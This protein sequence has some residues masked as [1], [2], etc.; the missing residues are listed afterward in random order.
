MIV[1]FS[2]GT[3]MRQTARAL[4]R[5]GI[6]STHIITVFDSGGSSRQLRLAFGMPAVGDLRN[7]L[8]AMA[9]PQRANAAAFLNLR[10]PENADDPSLA[11]AWLDK[12]ALPQ[13]MSA[14]IRR[15]F[16]FFLDNVPASF[17]ASRASLGNMAITGAYLRFGR[18]LVKAID[19]YAKLLGIKG[20]ILPVSNAC[21]QLAAHLVDDQIIIGQ[22][23]FKSLPAAVDSIYLCGEDG[24][25]EDALAEPNALAA[26]RAADII[27]Y[28]TGSFYSSLIANLL[29]VGVGSAIA[30]SGAIKLYIPNT[31]HDPENTSLNLPAQAATIINYASQDSHAP[32]TQNLLNAILID[33]VNGQYPGGYGPEDRGRL[34]AMGLRVIEAPVAGAPNLHNAAAVVNELVKLSPA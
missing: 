16:L 22:H 10:L 11:L 18:D 30:Q 4:V 15:D 13:A 29:P 17:K 1:F 21:R 34:Q 20:K 3:G 14:D 27:C 25:P 26:I 2:G 8:I 33:P 32:E 6:R 28:S 23:Q 7:R 19:L 24:E 9:S 31:G 12:A 5:G